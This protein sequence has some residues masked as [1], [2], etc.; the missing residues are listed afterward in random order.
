MKKIIILTVLLV[1]CAITYAQNFQFPNS[2][3]ENWEMASN[4]FDSLVNWNTT[5]NGLEIDPYYDLTTA[6]PEMN[7]YEGD[8]ALRLKAYIAHYMHSGDTI[9]IASYGDYNTWKG[10]PF[11]GM[12]RP[13]AFSFYYKFT[14]YD[15]NDTDTARVIL[16][17]YKS[18]SLIGSIDEFKVFAS[19]VETFTYEQRDIHWEG[20]EIPDTVL[21][22][23]SSG[24]LG[25]APNCVYNQI[26]IDNL[27]LHYT[28][29]IETAAEEKTFSFYPSNVNDF[30]YLSFDKPISTNYQFVAYSITGKQVFEQSINEMHSRIDL[31]S[32]QSGMYIYY[33]YDE[34]KLKAGS[35]KL[36]KH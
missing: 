17:F 31:S 1:V 16:E 8:Y 25:L 33:L 4:G 18:G 19:P 3:F 12:N 21:L 28:S 29:D 10:K 34:N 7:A 24:N 30:A 36:L 5:N 11:T 32:L 26:T 6:F 9:A 35:G 23:I 15:L 27:A 13:H 22:V 20:E 2:N 14:P